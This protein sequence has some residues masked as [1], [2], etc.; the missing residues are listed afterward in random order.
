[1]RILVTGADGKLGRECV[2]VMSERHDV[3]GADLP[4]A[5]ITDANV[6]RELVD[7]VRPQVIVNCAAFTKVDEAEQERDRCNMVNAQGPM[8]LAQAAREA[9][10]QMVQVS[11]DYVF[12][13]KLPSPRCYTEKDETNPLSWY[14][15]TKHAGEQMVMETL[16]GALVVRTAW[17]YSV[18]GSSFPTLILQKLVREPQRQLWV[19]ND[20]HG[21]PT[22]ARSL[23]RQMLALI[24]GEAHGLYH[25]A[26]TGHATWF[27]FAREF[28]HGMGL[29][30]PLEPCR[31]SDNARTAA[32]PINS[33]LDVA[34]L[35]AEGRCL[36]REW[37]E[38]IAEFARLHG[39]QLL[40]A[41]RSAPQ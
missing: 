31:T 39:P 11:T 30:H 18:H 34:R 14:G 6:V 36:M 8:I 25:A 9:G 40:E 3:V 12:D 37:R 38:D 29:A 19:V 32:R 4:E 22:W 1:M 35:R 13:G 23:A 10:S 2:E 5:D 20:Q 16:P 28:L 15:R 24:E 26:G 17:L 7:S 41:A 27:D 21:S 33:A